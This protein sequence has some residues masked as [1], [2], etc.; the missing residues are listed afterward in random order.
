MGELKRFVTKNFKSA[1]SEVVDEDA[2][3]QKIDAVLNSINLQ[4]SV[5]DPDSVVTREEEES[6]ARFQV[7]PV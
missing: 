4:S 1:I 6:E 3:M 7:E 2:F 5:A